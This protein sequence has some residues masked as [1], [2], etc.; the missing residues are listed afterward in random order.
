[1]LRCGGA[2]PPDATGASPD[3]GPSDASMSQDAPQTARPGAAKP[4]GTLYVVATPLGNL[5]DITLRALE[6]L[7]TVDWVAAEDTRRSRTLL[8]H[9]GIDARL[10]PAHEHNE[11][12]AS[13]RVVAALRAGDTVALVTDA[14][15]PGISDPG[16]KVVAEVR[17]AGCPVV[18]VPGPSALAAAL[19]V[20]GFDT[21]SVLFKGFLP[22]KAAARQAV[23]ATLADRVETLVFYEA[24]HRVLEA[25]T[26]MAAHLAGDREI[27]IARELTKLFES[28]HVC[29]LADAPDWLAGDPNRLRGEFVLVVGPAEPAGR[30]AIALQTR[31]ALEIL[32][33]DL[34][35]KQAVGLASEICDT[36]R[37][38]LYDLAL[39]LTGRR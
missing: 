13:G 14:G 8:S 18:P 38:A 16:A 28:L 31:R 15:T 34:P 9:H 39:A 12:V 33:R 23:L 1:M 2:G 32:L 4:L 3:Y 24:P 11:R 27:F 19:S 26:D 20:C 6:V 17:Q 7:R 30:D 5:A 21:S 35:L 10:F 36:P 29:A 22:S 25:V 37:K